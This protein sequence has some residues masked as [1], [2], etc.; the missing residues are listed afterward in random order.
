[1]NANDYT[2]S[3]GAGTAL[4]QP[5]AILAWLRQIARGRTADPFWA[6]PALAG[7]ALLAA[8]LY[9]INLTV[10]GYANTYY[11]AAALA[12]SKSWSAWFFGSF[13]AANFITIDKPPLALWVIGLSVRLFGLS[14]WSVLLPQALAGVATVVL[15][16][17]DRAPHVRTRRGHHR[18]G[19]HGPHA[20]GC[21]HLPVRQPG[22]RADLA[23]R[24]RG[25]RIPAGPGGRPHPLAGAGG[26]PRWLGLPHQ[27]PAGIPRAA[28]I[29]RH[30]RH[31]RPGQPAPQAGRS[32]RE[33][34][35]RAPGE[36]LVGGHRAGHPGDGS[37][38]HR[39]Q[40][41]QLRARP[42]LRLRRPGPHLRWLGQPGR[43]GRGRWRGWRLL[44]HAGSAAL[45]QH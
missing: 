25:V 7:S 9:L 23:P 40:H 5:P 16:L 42:H 21:P 3:V 45:V 6:R 37:A 34:R 2:P 32:A 36:R 10:S 14:S 35:R 1:M 22:R 43:G 19:R 4:A 29:R 24:R 26:R 12:A 13:D 39:R 33:R 15:L 27:V 31:R 30:L 44:G 20:G 17:A 38:V 18:R 11:A 28:R 41:Q 8:A